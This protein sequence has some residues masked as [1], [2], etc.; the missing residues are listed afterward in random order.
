MPPRQSAN[1]SSSGR[2]QAGQHRPGSIP[3]APPSSFSGALLL[4]AFRPCDSLS[5]GVRLVG[6][7]V[8]L[9]AEEVFSCG[10]AASLLPIPLA[11]W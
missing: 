6:P 3:K 8:T 11:K 9:Q 5:T 7:S 2:D 4:F 10:L 1:Q